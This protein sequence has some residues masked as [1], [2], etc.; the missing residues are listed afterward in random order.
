MSRE[1]YLKTGKWLVGL[2]SISPDTFKIAV[3]NQNQTAL[4]PPY[5]TQKIT[6]QVEWDANRENSTE[7]RGNKFFQKARRFWYFT[8]RVEIVGSAKNPNQAELI[9]ERLLDSLRNYEATQ[10]ALLPDL[11]FI[12]ILSG[13]ISV[14]DKLG[15]D[16]QPKVIFDLEMNASKLIEHET[17]V[18]CSVSIDG[19][20]NASPTD[21]IEDTINISVPM[22]N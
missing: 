16:F 19:K 12:R 22:E 11:S 17:N 20:L 3:A 6:S 5:L 13:P 15:S 9:A 8:L 18:I 14:D 7:K 10:D 2:A 4:T 21:A 1:I